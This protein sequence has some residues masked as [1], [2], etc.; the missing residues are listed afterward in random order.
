M[1]YQSASL[2]E[3]TKYAQ[4]LA[5]A[6]DL[7]PKG[8]R[9]DDNQPSPGKILLVM[10][11]GA[12]L[13]LNP[14]AALQGIDV[15][16]GKATISPQLMSGLVRAAGHKIDI[17]S[18]GSIAQGDFMVKVALTRSDDGTVYESVWDPHRA[19]RADL[20]AY[21][22]QSDGTWK[23]IAASKYGK[24]LP[25]QSY[26][27]TMC[28]WRALGDVCREGADDVL[29][30]IAYTREEIESAVSIAE[31]PEPEATEEWE[32]LL[33][34]AQTVEEVNEI[35][36]RIKQKGEGTDA[37][38]VK[39]AT[40]LGVIEAEANIEDAEEVNDDERDA[41]EPADAAAAESAPD[42]VG[43]GDQSV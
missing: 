21:T 29:K 35:S 1:A 4:T 10:E 33:D 24:A 27:E 8:L 41:D 25:W 34:A 39:R 20:C 18:A 9:G 32:A 16:E 31:D 15:I 12:M 22:R 26:P 2:T 43:S 19:A 5:H 3:R 23:V 38:R 42:E 7:I 30:G 17:Q 36:D 37:L 11:T 6:G 40:R 13:G 14:M 28:K